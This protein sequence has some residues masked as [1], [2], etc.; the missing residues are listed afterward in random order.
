MQNH[1]KFLEFREKY[2]EFIYEKYE[3]IETEEDYKLIFTFNIPN[4]TTFEPTTTIPKKGIK[5]TNINKE[6]FNE[7]VFHIGLIELV[8]YFKCT[9]SPNV[10]IKCGYLNDDQIS[11][12]K[13]L[14]YNGLGEF[15]YINGINITEEELMHITCM[16]EKTKLP[17][18]NYQGVGNLIPIGGGKDSVVTLELLNNEKEINSPFIINPKEVT[19]NCCKADGYNEEDIISVK[20]TI[21]KNLIELNKKGFLN[22]HTPFSSLVAFVTYLCAYLSGK[23]YILLSNEASANEP[24]VP[25]T[26][27]NHQYSKTYEFENDF[28]IYTKKYFNIEIDYFSFLRPLHEIQIGMLFSQFKKYYNVVR[29]CNIGSKSIPWEWCCNCP[30]CLFVYIILSPFLEKVELINM[31]GQDLFENKELLNTFIE[32]L[33]YSETKPFECIGT[34][35]EVRLAVSLTIKN[36]QGELPYLLKYYSDNYPL[37]LDDSVLYSYNKENNLTEKFAIIL[38]EELKKYEKRNN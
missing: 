28:N 20:R 19:I 23:R 30:K 17:S 27:I 11:W 6:Y 16:K 29:S 34:Y 22:G 25:G 31:F 2:P 15:L 1:N 38:K 32:L 24:T 5:N 13:K 18:I 36:Y 21:D 9:C 10:I 26:N 7:L 35:S 8:S 33:G 14:Y 12:F 4:L 37:E 3:I